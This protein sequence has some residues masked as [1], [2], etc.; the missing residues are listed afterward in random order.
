MSSDFN[1]LVFK[2]SPCVGLA[3]KGERILSC[4]CCLGRLDG[5]IQIFICAVRIRRW[6]GEF[7]TLGA[8]VT[9]WKWHSHKKKYQTEI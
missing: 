4:R 8:Y 6:R 1:K 9:R 7:S 2:I 5:L 3:S